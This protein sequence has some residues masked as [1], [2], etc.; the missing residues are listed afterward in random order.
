MQ[1]RQVQ[2]QV[3]HPL[4][5]RKDARQLHP[6]RAQDVRPVLLQ[7]APR[8]ARLGHPG[9]VLLHAEVRPR[10]ARERQGDPE[11][12]RGHEIPPGLLRAAGRRHGPDALPR[13]G[14]ARLAEQHHGTLEGDAGHPS[15]YDPGG[16]SRRPARSR[17]GRRQRDQVPDDRSLR[18]QAATVV[19][20]RQR[21]V[22]EGL[23]GLHQVQTLA[24]Q[25]AEAHVQGQAEPGG[26]GG[27]AQRHE[28]E[29]QDEARGRRGRLEPGL[30]QD[31]HPHRPRPARAPTSGSGQ[32]PEAS[33]LPRPL[34]G[35][36]RVYVQEQVPAPAGHHPSQLQGELRDQ[37][38]SR[39]QHVEQLRH[40]S[41]RVRRPQDPLR[42]EQEAGHQHAHQHHVEVRQGPRDRVQ[43][44]PQRA[45]GVLGR[46]R[47]RVHHLRPSVSHVSRSR[48][49]WPCYL[50]SRS[51]SEPTSGCSG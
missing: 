18:H 45:P 23:A 30:P 8:V 22:P 21:R 25:H 12:E 9:P 42:L 48:R 7:G 6:A 20:R 13:H 14:A 33:H 32:P 5:R 36:H 24:S 39:A 1:R 26:H 11:H 46:R 4:L 40:P 16:G 37:P 50:Q 17:A 27:Q 19:L 34:R 41:A 43:G 3:L 51:C 28:S 31:R 29:H 47:R 35:Q 15:G 10:L 2:H 38:R 49:G 44:R